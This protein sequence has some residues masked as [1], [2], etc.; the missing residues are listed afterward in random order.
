MMLLQVTHMPLTVTMK[1]YYIEGVFP[2]V[3]VI[4]HQLPLSVKRK[5]TA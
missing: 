3:T 1:T 4:D 2:F 5:T